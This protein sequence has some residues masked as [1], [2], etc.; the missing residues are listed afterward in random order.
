MYFNP[1]NLT[2]SEFKKFA[3]LIYESTGIIM[4]DGKN[5]LL[6]NRLKKRLNALSLNGYS[7]YYDYLQN[8]E[9]YEKNTEF[10]MFFDVVSTHETFFFRHEHN[11]TALSNVCFNEI[12]ES[13]R[14]RELRI[15]SAACST[16]EEPYSIAMCL[17]DKKSLFAGWNLEIIATDISVPVLKAAEEGKYSGRRIAKVPP[18]HLSLYFDKD[19]DNPDTYTVRDEVK[20]IIRFSRL[21]F[22]EDPFP[23]NID[24]IFCRN[25]MIY[26][27]REHQERLIQGFSKIINDP[28]F[29]FIGHAETLN[30][31]SCGFKYRK[32]LES[33]VYILTNE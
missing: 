25:V 15:W 6:S 2:D 9:G 16:G 22:F 31:I 8:L 19:K 24:I 10:D 17:L 1:K 26:F 33:P 21:N 32:I 12:A 29:L 4:K 7:E 5:T 30:N 13:K 14:I 23:K 27:D 3:A 11:F 20:R 18:H 28:G